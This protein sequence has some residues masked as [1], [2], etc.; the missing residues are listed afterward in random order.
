[1]I[2]ERQKT[3][4][5]RKRVKKPK[6]PKTNVDAETICES[7][8]EADNDEE[9]DETEEDERDCDSNVLAV[10]D[11][12]TKEALLVNIKNPTL[13]SSNIYKLFHFQFFPERKR[14]IH[15]IG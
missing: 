1:M 7:D 9:D 4:P 5:R 10:A 6:A 8:D 12:Q 15:P 2:T 14:N 3:L 13:F 11:T